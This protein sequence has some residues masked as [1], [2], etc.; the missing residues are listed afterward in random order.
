MDA[1]AT[2][3]YAD[4]IHSNANI[5]FPPA[6]EQPFFQRA[7]SFDQRSSPSIS[8]FLDN[9]EV[10]PVSMLS[11]QRM[12]CIMKCIARW[13]IFE[14]EETK[15]EI[16]SGSRKAKI[17]V[18]TWNLHGRLPGMIEACTL[19]GI[20]K[21]AH[22]I[23]VV[24]TQECQRSIAA[25]L[26]LKSKVAWENCVKYILH[27][28]FLNNNSNRKV[29]GKDYVM[30]CSDTLMATHIAVYVRISLLPSIKSILISYQFFTLDIHIDH[31]ATGIGNTLGNKGGVSI[32]FCIGAA[33]L[34][35]ICVHL[36]GT[37]INDTKYNSW[38]ECSRQTKSRL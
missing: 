11:R 18:C 28:P 5:S 14:Q 26:I 8:T 1:E 15:D 12:V 7:K 36:A 3:M 6:S 21:T 32:S 22:D 4:I 10:L 23:Y 37:T 19:L 17:L 27:P 16:A 34:T 25:S 35:F 2:K 20:N 30:I 33:K 24:G 31:V 13:K 29:L 9:K 38:T